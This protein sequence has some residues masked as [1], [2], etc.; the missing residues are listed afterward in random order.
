MQINTVL[1]IGSITKQFTAVSIMKLAEQGYI[2]LT[3]KISMYIKDYPQGDRITI[4]NLLRNTSG[5]KSF[6]QL[7]K[8]KGK[9]GKLRDYSP[10][11]V[12]EEIKKVPLEF[13]PGSQWSYSNSGYFISGFIIEQITGKT[14]QKYLEENIFQPLGL[15][16]LYYDSNTEIIKRKAMGYKIENNTILQA[17][18][19]SMS[20]AYSADNIFNNC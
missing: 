16:N 7:E 9:D 4:E 13:E 11:E 2:S 3:D 12:I 18:Y 1:G 20:L 5:I 6:K 19:L 17:D 8:F 15:Q 10:S 14:Y